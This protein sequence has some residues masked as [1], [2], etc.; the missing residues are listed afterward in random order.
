MKFNVVK[1]H[2]FILPIINCR[3]S[4]WTSTYIRQVL[5]FNYSLYNGYVMILLLKSPE[6]TPIKYQ[7]SNEKYQLSGIKYQVLFIKY[8]VSGIKYKVSIIRYQV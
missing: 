2:F 1:L 8:Q 6:T 4:M 7:V 5:L 3:Y